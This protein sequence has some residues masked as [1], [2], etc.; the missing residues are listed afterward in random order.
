APCAGCG[1]SARGSSVLSTEYSV[2]RHTMPDQE[3]ARDERL[4]GLLEE[5]LATLRQ[6]GTLDVAAWQTHHPDLADD[7]P[8]LLETLR[9]LDTAVDDWKA[10][11]QPATLSV[12][13]GVP[14]PLDRPLPPA[15][16]RYE[17][18]AVLGE[19]GMGTVYKAH[20]PQLRR[21]VAVKVPRF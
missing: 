4:A 16:G 3:S 14:R 11:A 15:I 20:D 17:I 21:Q 12:P 7:L 9:N 10:R 18:L 1:K 19:G 13:A 2:R 5:A 6:T 8:A